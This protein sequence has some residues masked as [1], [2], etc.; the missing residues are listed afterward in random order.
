LGTGIQV[1]Q[2]L[3]LPDKGL[4]SL[5]QALH[6][7]SDGLA[8]KFPVQGRIVGWFGMFATRCGGIG[9][10]WEVQG[11]STPDGICGDAI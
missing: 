4:D 6:M 3:Q 7:V 11:G 8:G 9:I 2:M 5:N 10:E 1:E